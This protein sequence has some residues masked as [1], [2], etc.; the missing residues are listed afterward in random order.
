MFVLPSMIA[1]AAFRRATTVASYGQR[2]RPPGRD[3]RVGLAGRR[4][5]GVPGHGNKRVQRFAN[6]VDAIEQSLGQLDRREFA[7]IQPAAQLR[8]RALMQCLTH[9]MPYS[10]TRGTM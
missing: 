2:L 5:R 7:V 1:P 4:Q 8:E 9:G 10:M 3:I 6:A